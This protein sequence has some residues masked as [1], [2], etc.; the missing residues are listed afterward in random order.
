MFTRCPGDGGDPDVPIADEVH[1]GHPWR[2]TARAG[3]VKGE[4]DAWLKPGS[5]L[6]AG[7]PSDDRSDPIG[8]HDHVGA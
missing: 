2:R 4:A 7:R 3:Q 1:P 6:D 8:A 5:S